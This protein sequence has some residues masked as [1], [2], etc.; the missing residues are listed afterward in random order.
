MRAETFSSRRRH[1]RHC[2]AAGPPIATPRRRR[3]DL[4][5]CAFACRRAPKSS[6]RS[7][8]A[9]A[10]YLALQ[11]AGLFVARREFVRGADRCD[12]LGLFFGKRAF[13]GGAGGDHV[14]AARLALGF[15]G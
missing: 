1:W 15:V 8:A 10:R 9:A 6:G 2:V 3:A 7:V 5:V 14:L 12:L 4:C 13:L 11:K